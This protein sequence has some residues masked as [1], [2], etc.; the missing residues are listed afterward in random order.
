MWWRVGVRETK[1]APR[2]ALSAAPGEKGNP[3][4]GVKGGQGGVI[5]IIIIIIN[6]NNPPSFT[7]KKNVAATFTSSSPLLPVVT[8]AVR[9]RV[10]M[11]QVR[12]WDLGPEWE[13]RNFSRTIPHFLSVGGRMV[14]VTI[15]PP[16][17]LPQQHRQ[18][19]AT[20]SGVTRAL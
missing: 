2:K 11:S 10:S 13:V 20:A 3:V 18:R 14:V 17:S 19:C 15:A 6:N 7:I 4:K 16:S 9:M 12:R 8:V 5:I 1:G